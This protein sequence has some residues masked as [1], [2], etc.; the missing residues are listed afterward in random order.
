MRTES[1][2]LCLSPLRI[3]LLRFDEFLQSVE[4]FFYACVV[5][6]YDHS[7]FWTLNYVIP[8]RP[9]LCLVMEP[10]GTW[11]GASSGLKVVCWLVVQ[12]TSNPASSKSA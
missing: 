8:S 10:Q 3:S 5:I 12:P 6:H 7:P 9:C 4:I 1:Q 2:I 11:L